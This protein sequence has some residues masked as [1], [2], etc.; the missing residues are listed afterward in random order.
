MDMTQNN[1]LFIGACSVK[2]LLEFDQY[3]MTVPDIYEHCHY[4]LVIPMV[5]CQHGMELNLMENIKLVSMEW[6]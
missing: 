6:N 1:M 2:C 5:F 4:I 3:I